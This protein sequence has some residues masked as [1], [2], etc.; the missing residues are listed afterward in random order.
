LILK[1]EEYNLNNADWAPADKYGNASDTLEAGEES[2]H[3]A[4]AEV[5]Q[6]PTLSETESPIEV[7]G[8]SDAAATV[9]QVVNLSPFDGFS[10]LRADDS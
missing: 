9:S 3:D 4:P 5:Y 7:A 6:D 8:S 10:S 2:A 1:P